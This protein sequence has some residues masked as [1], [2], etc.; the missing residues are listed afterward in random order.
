MFTVDIK[1]YTGDTGETFL[2]VG[3]VRYISFWVIDWNLK[4][5][6]YIFFIFLQILFSFTKVNLLNLLK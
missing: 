5:N 6:Y 1:W 3:P 2:F 4:L